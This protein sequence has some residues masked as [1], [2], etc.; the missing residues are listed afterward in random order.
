VY[1]PSCG[2]QIPDDAN[3]CP[4][5]GFQVRLLL[6]QAYPPPVKP[7]PSR[8]LSISIAAFLLALIGFLS[9]ISGAFM[10]FAYIYISESCVSIPFFGQLLT[11]AMLPYAVEGLIL[12]ALFITSANWLWKCKKSG[13]YLAIMLLIID[14]LS[15]LGLTASNSYFTPI[16]LVGLA[17]SLAILLLI[18]LGWSSLT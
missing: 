12:G 17:L 18:A 6:Q 2:R 15:G 7:Q 16:L 8:P 1:C 10:F 14:M 4:Y 3:I 13:G 5:C 9:V 11:T